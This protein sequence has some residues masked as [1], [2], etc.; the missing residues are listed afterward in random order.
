MKHGIIQGV[1]LGERAK[2]AKILPNIEGGV[3]PLRAKV[4]GGGCLIA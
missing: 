1:L 2:R 3:E 4:D